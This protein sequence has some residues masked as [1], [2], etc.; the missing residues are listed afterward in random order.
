MRWSEEGATLM[1]SNTALLVV[2]ARFAGKVVDPNAVAV[3]TDGDSTD[4]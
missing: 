2:R 4:G 3:M 1:R